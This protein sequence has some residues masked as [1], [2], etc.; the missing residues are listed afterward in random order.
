MDC[1]DLTREQ[2]EQLQEHAGR[3]SRYYDA[4]RERMQGRGFPYDDELRQ[5]V[6]A[7]CDDLHSLWVKLHY[8]ACKGQSGGRSRGTAGNLRDAYCL[9]VVAT[10]DAPFSPQFMQHVEAETPLEA[11]V[12]L[13]RQ[14]ML[15]NKMDPFWVRTVVDGRIGR[16]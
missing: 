14:G 8:L 1:Q 4:L 15:S 12:K 6:N 2:L 16:A 7:V 10:P 9:Q 13:A 11:I 5:A 3:T